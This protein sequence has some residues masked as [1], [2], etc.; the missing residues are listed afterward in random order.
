MSS[1]DTLPNEPAQAVHCP[2]CQALQAI[3]PV[4]VLRPDDKALGDLLRGTLNQVVCAACG[5]RFLVNV[6]LV[7]RDDARRHVVYF[8]PLDDPRTWP[9]AEEQMAHLTETV[10]ADA[11]E[12]AEE[13]P[14]IRLTVTRK[15][16]IE[17][18]ELHLHGLD[19]RLIEYLKFQL[20]NNPDNAIDPVRHELLYNFSAPADENVS[21]ILFDRETG[22]ATAGAD[23]P[24]A[25]IDE[26]SETLLGAGGVADEL[27][28]L[29]PG[30]YVCVDRLL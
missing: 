28:G 9:E 10:F 22:Q 3:D 7:F 11:D 2:H 16:F 26:L 14:E 29:F 27:R 4:S 18:I 1:T 13:L 20:Y 12:D 8:M 30:F 19:D 15:A 5:T 21:F 23:L 25:L 17:K 6:P 24:R